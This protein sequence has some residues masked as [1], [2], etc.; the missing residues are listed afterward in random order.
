VPAAGVAGWLS[1]EMLLVWISPRSGSKEECV[2]QIRIRSALAV[3]INHK[4]ELMSGIIGVDP[5]KA[6]HTA[7]AIS[8]DEC[9]LAKVTVRA[10]CQ[11]TAKLL[12]WAETFSD[13]TWAIES[14]GGLGYLLAQQ[15]VEAGEH[16]VDVPPTLASRVRVLGTGRSEKND[17]NDALS[18]AIAALRSRSLRTVERADHTEIMRLLAKRNYDL[19]RLWA[20]LVC[21][22]HNALA[23]LSPGGIAKELYVSDAHRLLESFDPCTPIEH[24]RCQLAL[25]LADDVARLDEQIKESHRRIRTAV[26][27]S[28]TSLTELYGIGPILAC[29]LIGYTGDVRRFAN[30]D[31]FA[32]YAGIAPVEHSSAGRVFHRLSLRGH[33]RLNNAIHM[34]ALTQIRNPGTADRLYFERKVTEGKTKREALRSLNARF[35]T[36]STG[37]S[38]STPVRRS[39][40]TPRD[41]S[42]PA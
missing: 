37:N 2:H 14:A 30:R 31:R 1:F 36:S 9:E 25:E 5:H 10:T 26:R 7:V 18:V 38:S 3:A 4:E 13:R 39:G 41:D 19:G 6:S 12:A 29:A 34:V 23:D 22:L 35:Q 42:V 21:R 33:R 27:A 28:K 15:L 17:P 40:R 32:A 24:R 11:Q 16:V 8:G 20:R